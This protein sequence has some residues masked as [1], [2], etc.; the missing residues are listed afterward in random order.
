MSMHSRLYRLVCSASILSLLL[1][2]V[3]PFSIA[4]NPAAALVEAAPAAPQSVAD[5]PKLPAAALADSFA[6]GPVTVKA[7]NAGNEP[8]ADP[9]PAAATPFRSSPIMFI[10]NVGQFDATAKFQ[11]RG[12]NGTIYLAS[13]AMWFSFL[14]TPKTNAASSRTAPS[15]PRGNAISDNTPRKG[16]HVKMSFVGANAKP[17]IEPFDRLDTHVSYFKGNDASKWRTDVPVWGGVRYKELYPGIDLELTGATGQWQPRLVT[18]AGANLNSVQ[19]RVDGPDRL[20]SDANSLRLTTGIGEIQLPLFQLQGAAATGAPRPSVTGNQVKAPFASATAQP[21]VQAIV[22]DDPSALIYSTFVGGTND[23]L[24]YSDGGS[25]IAVDSTGAAYVTGS[26]AASDFV[27]TPGAFQTSYGG[28][29]WDAFVAKLDPTGSNLSYATFL[30]G[31]DADQGRAIAV[32]AGGAAYATGST[33]SSNFPFSPDAPYKFYGGSED[34]FLVK[35]NATGTVL[36]YGTFLGGSYNDQGWSIAVDGGGATYV[37]G[38]TQSQ[39][40]PTTPGAFDR[41]YNGPV[42]C[43]TWDAFVAKLNATGTAFDYS[44]YLGGSA[45]D[46]GFG[47]AVDSSG[48]A[49]ITGDTNSTDFPRA[50]G[51]NGALDA[52]VAKLNAAGSDLVYAVHLGG[53]SYDA[54]RG[55]AVDASGAAY[56][57]GYTYSPDFATSGAYDTILDGQYDAFAAKINATGSVRI[58]ATYLGGGG[59]EEGYGIAVDANGVAYATGITDSGDFP[60]TPGAFDT[61]YNGVYDIFVAKLEATGS[62]LFAT[63][64]GAPAGEYTPDIAIDAAGRAYV[65]GTT[66]SPNFPT[67][68]G[69]YDTS[70]G[71]TSDA[72][73]SKLTLGTPVTA[74]PVLPKK[75]KLTAAAAQG[76]GVPDGREPNDAAG[77][78]P[79]PVQTVGGPINT[80]TGAEDYTIV[81]LS[82]PALGGQMVF[83]RSYSSLA[84]DMYTT[85]LGYGWTH[86]QDTRLILPT[87]PGGTAG[88]ILF[89]PH[90]ANQFIFFDNGDG[91]YSPYAGVLAKLTATSSPVGYRIT[92]ADQSVY[93]FD[94]AGRLQT[95]ADAQGHQ[96]SYS[97]DAGRL[98]R[99]QDNGTP[100][101]FLSLGYD[102]NGRLS[103]VADP[104]NRTVQFGYDANGDLATFIDARNKTWTYRYD[105]TTHRLNQ[106]IDPSNNTVERTEYDAQGR[107]V[108]QFDAFNVKTLELQYNIDGTRVITDAVGSVITATYGARGTLDTLRDAAGITQKSFDTNFRPAQTTDANSHVTNLTWSADGANLTQVKDAQQRT[109][110]LYYDSLNNLTRT[111]D[112]L[113]RASNFTY[114]GRLL[115]RSADAL[116]NTTIY[117]YTV[118]GFLQAQTDARGNTTSYS[119]NPFG[120]RTSITDAMNNVTHYDYDLVGRLI[121]TTDALQHKTVNEYDNAD[122]LV[123][124]TQNYWAGQPQNHNNEYNIITQ[125]GYD[126]AGRRTTTTDTLGHVTKNDYDAAGQLIK[127]TQNYDAGQPQNGGSQYNLVTQYAYD[128]VGRQTFITDTLGYVSRNEYDTAGRLAKTTVNYLP[129]QPQNHQNQ[130]N[131]VTAYGYDA[132]GNV[133]SKT[134]TLGRVTRTEY[135]E[136]NRPWKVIAN[137]VDGV[138]NSGEPDKDLITTTTYDEVGNVKTTTDPLGHITRSDY[139]RLNRPTQVTVNYVDGIYTTT[140]PDKDLITLQHYDSVGNRDW[141]T[142]TLAYDTQTEYDALNRTYRVT[143]NPLGGQPQNYQNEYNIVTAY[144]FNEIGS[145]VAVTDTLGRVTRNDYDALNRVRTVTANYVPGAP[146]DAQTNV[147]TTYTYDAL[148]NRKT[149]TDPLSHMT[150]WDYDGLNRLTTETRPL[151]SVTQYGYDPRGN[152]TRVTDPRNHSTLYGYDALSRNTTITDTLSQVTQIAYD[153]AGR[154]TQ[155]TDPLGHAMTYGYDDAD[156]QTSATDALT[157]VTRYAYDGLGNRL[158]MTDARNDVTVYGYDA[159]NRLQTVI[160]NYINGGGS[161]EETNVT[162]QYY[163]DGL[164]NRTQIVDGLGHQTTFTY[165]RLNRLKTEVDALAHT[166]TYHYYP[167]GQRSML[168]DAKTQST[169]YTYDNLYR[170]TQTIYSADGTNEQFGYDAVGNRKVMTD[171]VGVTQYTYDDL[172]RLT[173]VVDPYNQTV[174]YQYDTAGNRTS[175]TYPDSKNVTYTYNP[176]NRLESVKDWSNQW[177]Y[178]G[179]DAAS[180]PISETLPNGVG[181]AYSYDNANR[182]TMVEYARGATLLARVGYTLDPV[183]NRVRQEESVRAVESSILGALRPGSGTQQIVLPFVSNQAQPVQPTVQSTQ[184]AILLPFLSNGG[185]GPSERRPVGVPN[186]PATGAAT[187]TATKTSTPMRT[188]TATG[189]PTPP[190]YGKPLTFGVLGSDD[191]LAVAGSPLALVELAS[192]PT[193][194]RTPTGAR[195]IPTVRLPTA[196]VTQPTRRA[197]STPVGA[198]T[199]LAVPGVAAAPATHTPTR[200]PTPSKTPT[201]TNTPTITPTPLPGDANNTIIEYTYDPLQRLRTAKYSTANGGPLS[202]LLARSRAAV[203]A[204]KA[205]NTPTPTNTATPTQT[206][207][208]VP[209]GVA[210][211][212]TYTYD[213]VG[214]RVTQNDNGTA[215]SYGY[216]IA[217]RLTS[218][219]GT[220]YSWDNNGNLLNDG[221]QAYSYDQANRLKQV[222]QGGNTYLF[223]YNGVG[224]RLSQTLNGTATRYVLDPGA[225]L[226]QVL[227]DGTNTYLYGNPSAGSGQAQR[228][229]Q[230]QTNMQYFGADGLGSVRQIYNSAGEIIAN[231]RYDPF[232]NVISQSGVGTSAYGYAGEW[233]DATGLEYLRA[234]YYSAAQGRFTTRDVWEGDPNAPM[235]YNAWLY[236]YANAVN[237]TDASGHDPWWCDDPKYSPDQAKKCHD[238]YNSRTWPDPLYVQGVPYYNQ[239]TES[240]GGTTACGP[241]SLLI[242]LRY[243]GRDTTLESIVDRAS[244]IPFSQGGFDPKCDKK[245]NPVCMAAGAMEKVAQ[246]YGMLTEAHDDWTWE[247]VRTQLV[248][249]R[250]VIADINITSNGQPATTPPG[251]DKQY[252]GHFVVITG[253]EWANRR[254]RYHNPF[255]Y[256]GQ[257]NTRSFDAFNVAWNGPVDKD[258]PLQ[259]AGHRRWAM[260]AYR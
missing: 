244:K 161:N 80:D 235:S 83:Q 7:E 251:P 8:N 133:T 144:G 2:L 142:N 74:Q 4:W 134:D 191:S 108:R 154:R 258:D 89:K 212:I 153:A 65:A 160:E 84:T 119:Y 225:G 217:N 55:I 117:T 115:T 164:G 100:A 196:G 215:T 99:V 77:G 205:T 186:Q 166:T 54:G 198:I 214:N 110:S 15:V 132:A 1:N 242:V 24:G 17:V 220:T 163:Y 120:Q 135:D 14:E 3:S 122:H 146:A 185:V 227:A 43:N 159:A 92:G 190:A 226:T 116:G 31:S 35:L 221:A 111:V 143:Q 147:A 101:R 223:A 176:L 36:V 246:S 184:P 40:F 41:T 26:L 59:T 149:A 158:T 18:R 78:C 104:L 232:G 107:A 256:D 69:A 250:P 109:T 229:G 148:G 13:D 30:G 97:Y 79:C 57:T 260:A 208:P 106:I 189:T 237:L 231:R 118:E 247:Q 68:T 211:T 60:T 194:T 61:S 75:S 254:V 71:G 193:A 141:M 218:V 239:R 52:F 27:P 203:A 63:Y 255:P 224:D 73:V 195:G 201:V 42:C 222:T 82:F 44:T 175:I 81:D 228:L 9:A 58:Y 29:A 238:E 123:R 199:A 103:S 125:Y 230:Q 219:N 32:D 210:R 249:K 46:R 49:Y 88:Q 94:T 150:S 64:L 11:V 23:T 248:Q 129:G 28:G 105:G 209:W 213:A 90:S 170:L 19:L 202:P 126:D 233:T 33:S 173:Q 124:V 127:V 200:T 216:D 131:I 47:L 62:A 72:F 76:G 169:L 67:T 168:V 140:E 121:T 34:A 93:T 204:G 156:R 236:V 51:L 91:T 22:A 165:D 240:G 172:N 6:A 252:V 234:R 16:V 53:S 38:S 182:L 12:A 96:W 206:A 85:T 155:Q 162:T 207:T 95:W 259:P 48:A 180:R 167:T 178:Y 174:G 87:D 20:S 86:N 102:T 114:N 130:F 177:T 257:D 128:S 197:T 183:G 136:L 138:Y 179:Y 112:A 25:G 245:G 113:G 56:I 171:T 39:Y 145:R 241:A 187:Q 98:K 253:L 5:A 151:S 181:T 192:T 66:L 50:A 10:E 70:L 137:Y 139:D 188:P 157:N 152:R 243:Y 45:N 37:T 21:Q